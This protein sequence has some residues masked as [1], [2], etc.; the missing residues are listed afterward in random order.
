MNQTSLSV[1]DWRF[2][3][4]PSV[5]PWADFRW[6][7]QF[8]HQSP[9]LQVTFNDQLQK[10]GNRSFEWLFRCQSRE[11]GSELAVPNSAELSFKA[12]LFSDTAPARQTANFHSW[13]CAQA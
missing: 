5:Q 8:P 3:R 12:G 4:A 2:V 1:Q 9:G 13:S 6:I 7:L 11:E 10:A